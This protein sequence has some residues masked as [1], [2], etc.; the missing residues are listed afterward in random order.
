MGHIARYCPQHHWNLGNAHTNFTQANDYYE[1][2]E[3]L[4]VARAVANNHTPKERA[5][6]ILGHMANQD[7]EVKD[8]LIK[9]LQMNKDFQNA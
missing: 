1:Q 8:E 6:E 5:H 9:E 3:P 2:E 4:Q 7:E